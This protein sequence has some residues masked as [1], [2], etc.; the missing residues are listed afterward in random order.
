MLATEWQAFSSFNKWKLFYKFRVYNWSFQE[1]VHMILTRET[2][3]IQSLSAPYSS[4]ESCKIK[5]KVPK[6]NLLI[7][8]LFSFNKKYA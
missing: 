1:K 2:S 7:A 4:S 6:G 5:R 8:L 3:E